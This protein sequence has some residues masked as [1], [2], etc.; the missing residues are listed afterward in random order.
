MSLDSRESLP[1]FV[2]AERAWTIGE[3]LASAPH[4]EPGAGMA[5][6]Q[7][8][9]LPLQAAKP[10][11]VDAAVQAFRYRHQLVSGDECARWLAARGLSYAD[12]RAT[13][14]RQLSGAPPPDADA[15]QIE[16]ILSDGFSKLARELAARVAVALHAGA[17]RSGAVADLWPTLVAHH[18]A[19]AAGA[20]DPQARQR[21]LHSTRLEWVQIAFEQVEFDHLDAA[22][23]ARL[24]VL[25]DGQSLRQLATVGRF[26]HATRCERVATLPPAWTHALMRTRPGD[27]TP[28][29]RDGERLLLLGVI[30]LIEPTLNDPMVLAGI[31]AQLLDQHLEPL[32]ARH[33]RWQLRGFG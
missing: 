2:A 5:L 20:A 16:A 9:A 29:I 12:L 24:C 25:E 33:V 19:F 10:S 26:A 28:V 8:R 21:L 14:A 7:S 30:R 27:I 3:V 6:R 13:L 31:D 32:L 22:R 11:E 4:W 15:A 23:E 17:L 1:V 18:R